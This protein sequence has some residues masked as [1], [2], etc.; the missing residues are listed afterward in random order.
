MW[1]DH[2]AE[3]RLYKDLLLKQNHEV[4]YL[5]RNIELLQEDKKQLE[6]R[7]RYLE[8]A[9]NI[10]YN[11]YEEPKISSLE[12]FKSVATAIVAEDDLAY[13]VIIRCKVEDPKNEVSFSYYINKPE[14]VTARTAASI[15]TVLHKKAMEEIEKQLLL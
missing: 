10:P 5:K 3:N 6:A 2:E 9:T 8:K 1:K 11:I 7:V 14:L 15:L 12:E 13:H 4:E